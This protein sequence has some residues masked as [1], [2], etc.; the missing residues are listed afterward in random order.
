MTDT[1]DI[2]IYRMR[3]RSPLRIGE[4]T[5]GPDPKPIVLHS[6]SLWSAIISAGARLGLVDRLLGK[7]PTEGSSTFRLT[8]AFPYLLIDGDLVYFFPRPLCR[9]PFTSMREHKEQERELEKCDLVTKNLF[10][11]WICLSDPGAD[12]VASALEHLKTLETAIVAEDYPNVSLGYLAFKSQLFYTRRIHFA[13]SLGDT[14]TTCQDV[15]ENHF[16]NCEAGLWFGVQFQ[17][18]SIRRDFEAALELL[19]EDGLGGDRSTGNGSFFWESDRISL[20]IPK[21]PNGFVT[22]SL[23]SPNTRNRAMRDLLSN[24]TYRLLKRG[25]WFMN[26]N[27]QGL[28]KQIWVLSEGSVLPEIIDGTIRDVTPD[29]PPLPH[30]IYR[31]G[32]GFWIGIKVVS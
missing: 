32:K 24:S 15:L 25:G 7:D 3:L 29:S 30:R 13:G 2:L 18:Q 23:V 9:Q 26:G 31:F 11:S 27:L 19:S 12:S 14:S 8:S 20:K 21:D 1:I 5:V 17:D 16:R 10:E 6:D 4:S 22:L 28:R